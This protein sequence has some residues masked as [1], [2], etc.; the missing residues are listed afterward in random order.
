MN[1]DQARVPASVADALRH[2]GTAEAATR[3]LVHVISVDAIRDAVGSRW[4]RHQ[5][6]VEEF[7]LRSFRRG[8]RDDDFVVRVNECD[9]I[10][11]QPGRDAAS[12]LNRASLLMR[13]TLNYFLG[14]TRAEDLRIAVVE[15]LHGEGMSVRPV[16]PEDVESATQSQTS[17]LSQSEDGSPPWERFGVNGDIAAPKIVMIRRPDG[18]QI[19]AA[20]WLEP[21]WKVSRECVVSFTVEMAA[22]EIDEA[23]G[24]V[25]MDEASMTT[26]CGASLVQK[27]MEFARETTER[28][29]A[30]DGGVSWGLHLPIPFDAVS[31]ST[32]RMTVLAELKKLSTAGWRDRL[33]LELTGTPPGLPQVRLSEIVAQLK[34]YGRAVMVR[35][36]PIPP[37]LRGWARSGLTGVVMPAALG[38][39]ERMQMARMDAFARQC[40]ALRLVS[41]IRGIPSRSLAVAAWGA[42]VAMISGPLISER[43]GA[44][45]EARR[46]PPVRMYDQAAA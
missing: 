28:A 21:V 2:A 33:F 30:G 14:A 24:R 8:A 25:P 4:A 3:G 12:A 10:L 18:S 45:L 15:G 13:A 23:G 31:H 27:A 29:G 20:F 17:D 37:D 16:V 35:T 39:S 11:I 9:F 1:I 46:F 43:Y 44:G 6:V 40:E 19:E 42:G 36:P 41:A 34:P 26:R 38:V 22:F 7:V 5:S 32:T